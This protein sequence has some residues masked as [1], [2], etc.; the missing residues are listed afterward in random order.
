MN[1]S[2]TNKPYDTPPPLQVLSPLHRAGRQVSIFL[3]ARLAPLGLASA[4]AHLL[5]YVA[6]Y[7]PCRVAELSRVF[8]YKGPTMTGMLDRLETRDW[9]ARDVNPDD[10]RS[11]LVSATG[12]GARVADAARAIVERL[13]GE[14][15]NQVT[16]ADLEAFHKVV[17]A[18]DTRTGV[19]VRAVEKD[20]S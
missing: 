20:S 11:F 18:V 12:A 19:D 17:T 5:A 7:G 3:E 8:G 14:I 15:A 9:V 13:D 6:V 1:N 10:R 16:P 2:Q 4:E